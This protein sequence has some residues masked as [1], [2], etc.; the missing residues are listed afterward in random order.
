MDE[1]RGHDGQSRSNHCGFLQC[2]RTLWLSFVIAS[3]S[4]YQLVSF[5]SWPQHQRIFLPSSGSLI[6]RKGSPVGRLQCPTPVIDFSDALPAR[7]GGIVLALL[8]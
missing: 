5:E 4:I 6:V 7:G 3:P 8:A 1:G 2:S